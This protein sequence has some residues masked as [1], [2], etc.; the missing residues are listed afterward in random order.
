MFKAYELSL[1]IIRQ[2]EEVT[3]NGNKPNILTIQNDLEKVYNT[4]IDKLYLK[5][6]TEI[7]ERYFEV[8]VP[9]LIDGLFDFL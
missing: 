5:F 7:I 9:S 4:K 3:K 6:L 1:K 2:I 8:S